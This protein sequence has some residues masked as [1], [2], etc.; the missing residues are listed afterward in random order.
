MPRIKLYTSKK[1]LYKKYVKER[2]S[3][4]EI[5]ALAGTNQ[6]TINRW[7]RKFELKR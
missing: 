6:S 5:A 4:P 1:W 7:L 3:E 2:L